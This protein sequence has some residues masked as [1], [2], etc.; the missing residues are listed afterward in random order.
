LHII[1]GEGEK[2]K[3]TVRFW[4]V[5][6]STTLGAGSAIA[7]ARCWCDVYIN[8][9][10]PTTSTAPFYSLTDAVGLYFDHTIILGGD[11]GDCNNAC[12]SKYFEKE[13]DIA[14]FACAGGG[15]TNDH[16][17]ARAYV[18][19]R[20]G[21]MVVDYRTLTNAIAAPK[22]DKK[23]T[24]GWRANQT[25]VVNGFTADGRCKKEFP[26]QGF[27]VPGPP[28]STPI[29]GNW[30]FYWKGAVVAYSPPAMANNPQDVWVGTTP[31]VC[32]LN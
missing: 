13:Q 24:S 2:M 14:N 31:A 4:V 1:N 30:G 3:K 17:K 23:C 18:G 12:S 10:N 9:P 16:V 20:A 29:G 28:D 22:Y 8:S 21:S 11:I 5:A 27:N 32:K 25:N 7:G 19:A 26:I 6:L 15:T